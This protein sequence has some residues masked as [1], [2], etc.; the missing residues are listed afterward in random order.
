MPDIVTV[1]TRSPGDLGRTIAK[2][3]VFVTI[4][5]W[6]I[7]AIYFLFS[8][9][10]VR[11]LGDERFGQYS[12]V[13]AFVGLF[14]IFAELGLSQ[15]VM[16]EIARDRSK[17]SVFFWNLVAMRLL[18]GALGLVGITLGAIIAGYAPVLVLGIFINTCGFFL[19]AFHVPVETVLRANERLD[20]VT[21]LTILGQLTFVAVGSIILF[22]SQGFLWL[23][24]AGLVSLLPQIGGALWLI[25]RHR[26]ATLTFRLNPHLWMGMMRAGLPFGIISLALTIAFSI[27]TVMLSMFQPERVVGWYNVAYGLVRSL[28]SLFGGFSIA[29]VPSLARTYVTD[30]AQVERWYRR[31]VKFIMLLSLPIAVG[32]TLVAFPLI[33][34]LY[35][36]QFLPTAVGLQ[37][38]IWDVPLLMFTSFCGN[39]T[40]VVGEE[41][42][43]ARIYSINAV[44]NILLNWYAIPRFGL[45]G[46]A[47]VTVVTDLIGV[48]QFHFLLARKLRLPNVA[49]MLGRI[50][51]ASALMGI[52][53]WLAGNWHLFMVIG[54]GAVTYGGLVLA[55]R[56]IDQTEWAL[57]FRLVRRRSHNPPAKETA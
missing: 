36:A 57:L 19:S 38:L 6:A 3:T 48:L 50:V 7:K 12:I 8:V 26:L 52:V 5:T 24:V 25:K 28:V 54:L 29:M 15:Y 37:I 18:L 14:Q 53:V 11:R 51:I 41:R 16:R 10:V 2:N 1:E 49:W 47:L 33:R 30:S 39:M 17:A 23:I 55:L 32:G 42:A 43:A 20:Y 34:F 45:V 21:S 27:D 35:T 13:L 44:A 31:S 9:Y 4:Q 46:A 40:T 22:T 56:L